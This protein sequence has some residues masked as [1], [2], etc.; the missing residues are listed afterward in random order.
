MA[1]LV[2]LEVYGQIYQVAD[3]K[4]DYIMNIMQ[5]AKLCPGISKIYLFGSCL[6]ERCREESDVDITVFGDLTDSRMLHRSHYRNFSMA[7]VGNIQKEMGE[8]QDYDI[9]Y[10]HK[11]YEN[12]DN[13]FFENVRNGIVIYDREL[14]KV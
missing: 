3:I 10:Y 2:D 6:E 13:L 5:S 14:E 11:K 1:K 8:I 12:Y 9:L 7:V 4:K